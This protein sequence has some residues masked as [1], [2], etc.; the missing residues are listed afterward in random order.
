MKLSYTYYVIY[1]E[2]KDWGYDVGITNDLELRLWEHKGDNTP[3]Y[4]VM[5]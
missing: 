4:F 1:V 2:C 3:H 5:T